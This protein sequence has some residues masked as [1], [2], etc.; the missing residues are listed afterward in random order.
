LNRW[1]RSWKIQPGTEGE[2]MTSREIDK[3]FETFKRKMEERAAAAKVKLQYVGLD[4][5]ADE[6]YE[7]S[8]RFVKVVDSSEMI[9]WCDGGGVDLG[10]CLR[11]LMIDIGSKLETSVKRKSAKRR[12]KKR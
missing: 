9:M 8:A 6:G 1:V 5:D 11:N 2:E 4:W 10:Q 7:A 3:Q 12:K